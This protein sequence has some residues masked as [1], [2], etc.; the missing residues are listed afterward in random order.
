MTQKKRKN[1][2][3]LVLTVLISVVAV[4]GL[5]WFE[6]KPAPA[7]PAYE[8]RAKIEDHIPQTIEKTVEPTSSIADQQ[9][10]LVSP[11]SP[12][13]VTVSPM[14]RIAI[15]IDDMGLQAK[16][17]IQATELPAPVTLSYLPYAPNVQHQV[18]A[19]RAKGHEIMLH[20]PMEPLG[21]NNP[22][23]DALLVGLSPSEI[24]T[25]LTKAMNAFTGYDGINNHMGSKFTSDAAALQPVMAAIKQRGV[26]FLDSRTSGG[27]VAEAVAREHSIPAV[28][29]EVFLDD[30]IDVEAIRGQLAKTEAIARRKGYAIAI[31]HPHP[32]TLQVLNEWLPEA[33]S[34]GFQLVKVKELLP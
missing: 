27:S 7:P 16:Q 33:Q 19:A 34:K 13:P 31:G 30:T 26:F 12:P 23:P 24:D 15:V 4:V 9:L 2:T 32:Q 1:R 20:L 29:R 6:P 25:R 28:G 14:P 18:D 17:S 11:P 8:V 22:G 21:E 10:A 3:A 5:Y